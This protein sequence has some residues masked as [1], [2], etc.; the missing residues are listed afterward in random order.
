MARPAA[1]ETRPTEGLA[2]AEAAQ[3]V[4]RALGALSP[5]L[6]IVFVLVRLEGIGYAE[7]AEIVGL[8]VGTVKSR[9][10]AAEAFLRKHL[11]RGSGP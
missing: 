5:K 2:R 11:A 4:T 10:A 7:T 9:A 3:A 8:P 6:R 1:E